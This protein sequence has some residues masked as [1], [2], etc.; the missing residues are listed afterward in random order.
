MMNF[1]IPFLYLLRADRVLRIIH[2]SDYAVICDKKRFLNLSEKNY[3]FR[4]NNLQFRKHYPNSRIT[5]IKKKR[6]NQKVLILI[7]RK[8]REVSLG[9]LQLI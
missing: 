2:P 3:D 9:M 5:L 4:K 6:L 7:M 8:E 1:S